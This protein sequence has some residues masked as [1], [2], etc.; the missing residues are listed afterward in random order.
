MM[1]D[2]GD[3]TNGDLTLRAEEV[4]AGY[5]VFQ[6]SVYPQP[7]YN[8]YPSF[9]SWQTSSHQYFTGANGIDAILASGFK[10]F[11]PSC[12]SMFHD[13]QSGQSSSDGNG[14]SSD[15]H[16]FAARLA[17]LMTDLQGKTVGCLS[18]D[19]DPIP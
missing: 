1:F 5:N 10:A 17:Y 9:A 15:G 7:A 6:H 8:S 12:A 14:A 11:M 2:N 16:G 3:T 18:P 4:R 13:G 19:E